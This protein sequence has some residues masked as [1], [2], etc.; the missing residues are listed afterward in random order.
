[1]RLVSGR[2]GGRCG[3]WRVSLGLG[4]GDGGILFDGAPLARRTFRSRPTWPTENRYNNRMELPTLNPSRRGLLE[5]PHEELLAWL[6]DHGQPPMRAKQLRRWIVAGRA[7]LVRPDDRPAAGP[8]PTA[9]RRVRPA[10]HD[11]RPPPRFQ[12]RHAQAAAAP[13]RRPDRRMRAAAGGATAAPSASARRSAAAWAASSAPAASA[14]SC[15]TCRPPKS[16]NSCCTPA[17]C[18]RA[19]E[20]LTHI[21][22]MGMGEPMANLDALLEAL[23]DGRRRRQD[24]LG[25]GARHVTISTVGLPAKIRQLADLR[26]AVSPGRVAARPQRRAAQPD[27]A[28]Q[29]QDRP[30][31]HP[32][33]GRLFLREDRPAGDV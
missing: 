32:R 21:V 12:R 5:L 24:G 18:C 7:D 9:R 10:G 1:M 17:T 30:G 2:F 27:R 13:A 28:D 16:S 31:R 15:A 14:A 8:A 25:I 29:R 23:A 4:C 33:S 20:R 26:Q 6:K 3:A 19:H 22:V 11:G